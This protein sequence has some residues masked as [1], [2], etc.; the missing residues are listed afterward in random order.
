GVAGLQEALDVLAV[1]RQALRLTIGPEVAADVRPLVPGEAE[2]AQR[3]EDR[4]LAARGRAL[5]I[6]VLDPE[7]EAAAVLAGEDVVEEA[8]IGGADVGVAG[9]ARGDADPR[10][11]PAGDLGGRLRP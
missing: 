10:R 4:R 5:L 3:L 2:P 7:D 11:Q 1:D 8:D 6:G 9:R